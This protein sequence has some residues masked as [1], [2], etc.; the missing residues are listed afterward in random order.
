MSRKKMTEESKLKPKQ[1]KALWEVI[2]SELTCGEDNQETIN[3]INEIIIKAQKLRLEDIVNAAK[4]R[5]DLWRQMEN[6]LI[7]YEKSM[8]ISRDLIRIIAIKLS[9]AKM[10]EIIEDANFYYFEGEYEISQ[11]RYQEVFDYLENTL[12]FNFKGIDRKTRKFLKE[13]EVNFWSEKE[14]SDLME[15]MHKQNF[16]FSEHIRFW[17]SAEEYCMYRSEIEETFDIIRGDFEMD[18]GIDL[19]EAL[20]RLEGEMLL[21]PIE[22]LLIN[23]GEKSISETKLENQFSSYFLIKK[24]LYQKLLGFAQ[25]VKYDDIIGSLKKDIELCQKFELAKN[26]LKERFLSPLEDTLKKKD[27]MNNHFLLLHIKKNFTKLLEIAKI[28]SFEDIVKEAENLKKTY[29]DVFVMVEEA[30][31]NEKLFIIETSIQNGNFLESQKELEKI[32]NRSQEFNFNNLEKKALELKEICKDAELQRKTLL[33]EL[34]IIDELLKNSELLQAMSKIQNSIKIAQKYKFSNII[35]K[36]ENRLNKCKKGLESIKSEFQEKILQINSKIQEKDFQNAKKELNNIIKS[37]HPYNFV[38]IINQTRQILEKCEQMQR[39]EKKELAKKL[40]KIE[41]DI[42]NAK[43]VNAK[44]EL[45]IVINSARLY[46]FIEI[47]DIAKE[48]LSLCKKIEDNKK[49]LE[50]RFDVVNSKIL[51]ESFT[52]AFEELEKIIEEAKKSNFNIIINQAREK[53]N[54]CKMLFNVKTRLEK[55][56]QKIETLMNNEKFDLAIKKI[57]D[58]ENEAK[59]F[60]LQVTLSQANEKLNSCNNLFSKKEILKNRIQETEILIQKEQF[61]SAIQDLDGMMEEARK[62]GLKITMNQVLERIDSCKMLLNKK[63]KLK[64]Q[65][66]E[67]ELLMQEGK[68]S[69]CIQ[70]LNNIIEKAKKFNLHSIILCANEKSDLCKSFEENIIKILK[71]EHE[72]QKSLTKAEVIRNFE[73]N[74]DETELYLRFLNFTI[75]YNQS[76]VKEFKSAIKEIMTKLE[77]PDLYGLIS[78]FKLDFEIAK[79]IGKYLVD[80]EWITSFPRVAIKDISKEKLFETSPKK[81]VQLPLPFKAYN[82]TNPY[83][84]VS[85]SHADSQEVYPLIQWMHDEGFNIWYDEGIPP[86]SEW[87]DEIARAL[88]GC[89]FFIVFMTK[90]AMKSIYVRNEINFAINKG[91]KILSIFLEPFKLR[92]GLELLMGI[93]QYINEYDMEEA[94]FKKKVID[95]LHSIF[96]SDL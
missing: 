96:K 44:K 69:T 93:Y 65:I 39:E 87:P 40:E 4:E 23:S 49:N 62:S 32:L 34:S 79:K 38:H 53:Q 76:E 2:H 83:I 58:I 10:A 41:E 86:A 54:S 35:N 15:F 17:E 63:F 80:N 20:N 16:C 73:F 88:L 30:D 7:S 56:L 21:D 51:E 28:S 92:H 84:F 33:R 47:V 13:N 24:N 60:Q 25:L 29:K 14:L 43:L 46:E 64:K 31:L 26:N 36:M 70:S 45:S 37:A 55:E 52:T 74:V 71:L 77:R 61:K 9:P 11:K 48:K 3:Q 95:T 68:L 78:D 82:G 50:N 12:T 5:L 85:Y 1:V 67:I 66:Q 19:K 94:T 42:Q 6:K 57:H 59:K 18:T 8:G 72:E 81:D 91:K 27:I 90:S 75:D 89:E 22:N